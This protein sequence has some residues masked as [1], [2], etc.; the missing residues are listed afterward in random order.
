MEINSRMATNDTQKRQW[1]F[2]ALFFGTKQTLSADFAH[3]IRGVA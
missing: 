1:R 2:F 3:T